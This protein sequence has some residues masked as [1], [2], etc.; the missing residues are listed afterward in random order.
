MIYPRLLSRSFD[1]VSFRTN[2][3]SIASSQAWRLR[4]VA[5]WPA[6]LVRTSRDGNVLLSHATLAK[7]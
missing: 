1:M 7:S 6:R 3:S 4:L 5:T 2:G